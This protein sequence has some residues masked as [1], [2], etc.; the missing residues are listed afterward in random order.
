MNGATAE[1]SVRTTRSPRRSNVSA[2]G[3]S[4]YRFRRARKRTKSPAMA[5]F[6]ISCDSSLAA[7]GRRRGDSVGAEWLGPRDEPRLQRN[8]T[9]VGAAIIGMLDRLQR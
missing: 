4:Q 9:Q 7:P 2:I 8:P 6:D 5:I 3:K 1:P